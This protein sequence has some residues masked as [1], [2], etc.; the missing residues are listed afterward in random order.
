M[1]ETLSP[2]LFHSHDGRPST[3]A[4]A[5]VC[6]AQQMMSDARNVDD[7]EQL[8]KALAVVV[9][10]AHAQKWPRNLIFPVLGMLHGAMKRKLWKG[11]GVQVAVGGAFNRFLAA[12]INK[13]VLITQ[14]EDAPGW[15]DY[16]AALWFFT[17]DPDYVEELYLR[18]VYRLHGPAG[19]LT[20]QSALW[21]VNAIRGRYPDFEAALRSLEAR[22]KQPVPGV[23]AQ[24]LE[25]AP[26]LS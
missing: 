9:M 14:G 8:R 20:H 2:R 23:S 16:F 17:G 26:V 25:A 18:A 12:Y 6:A 10:Y 3:E 11:S 7:K 22:Y 1:P 5:A 4:A 15:N 13:S 21:L 24:D 19:A